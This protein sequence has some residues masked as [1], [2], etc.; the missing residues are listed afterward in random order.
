MAVKK[1]SLKIVLETICGIY[2]QSTFTCMI[3]NSNHKTPLVPSIGISKM[4]Y[5]FFV[6]SILQENFLQIS[7][8]QILAEVSMEFFK[9]EFKKN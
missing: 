6:L 9:S 2:F 5:V 8:N 1:K 7:I 3:L 4:L